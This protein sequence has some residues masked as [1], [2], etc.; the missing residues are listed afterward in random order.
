VTYHRAIYFASVMDCAR[1]EV[2]QLC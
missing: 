2:E 1:L